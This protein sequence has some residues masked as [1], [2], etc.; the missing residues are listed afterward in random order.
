M[1]TFIEI[2]SAGLEVYGK[3]RKQVDVVIFKYDKF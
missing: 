3:H 1:V 2:F